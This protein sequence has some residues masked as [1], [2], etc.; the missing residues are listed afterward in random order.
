M[1]IFV[2]I[3]K[4]IP[5]VMVRIKKANFYTKEKPVAQF[6]KGFIT[7]CDF[8]F[9]HLQTGSEILFLCFLKRQKPGEKKYTLRVNPGRDS[10]SS[11]QAAIWY[12]NK[13]YSNKKKIASGVGRWEEGKGLSSSLSLSHRPTR[14]LFFSLPSLPSTQRDLCAGEGEGL[15]SMCSS[16]E[17][18]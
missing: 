15:K 7:F 1:N 18:S 12:P 17:L 5:P 2:R 9:Q 13:K 8:F 11:A 3:Q 10:L 4:Q 16:S 6:V 14:A